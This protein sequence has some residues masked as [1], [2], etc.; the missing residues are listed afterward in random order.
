MSVNVVRDYFQANAGSASILDISTATNLDNKTISKAVSHLVKKG[1]LTV[2]DETR[3]NRIFQMTDPA[4]EEEVAHEEDT[5]SLSVVVDY[6]DNIGTRIAIF[7]AEG[8]KVVLT[9]EAAEKLCH[10][11]MAFLRI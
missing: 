6:W 2:T 9:Q 4:A 7:D 10:L 5:T 11:L 8:N 3:G 1:W